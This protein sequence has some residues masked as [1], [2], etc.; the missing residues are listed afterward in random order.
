MKWIEAA[1]AFALIMFVLATVVTIL[2]ESAYKLLLTREKS[3]RLMMARLFDE[4][5]RPRVGHLLRGVTIAQ[6]REGFLE[7]VTRNQAYE[8]KNDLVRQRVQPEQLTSMTMMQFADRLADTDVGKAIA[9]GGGEYVETAINDLAMKFERF[10][11]ASSQRF[12]DHA[13]FWCVVLSIGLAFAANVDAVRL[14]QSLLHDQDL[15]TRIVDKYQGL[16]EGGAA[17]PRDPI[18]SLRQ[19]AALKEQGVISQ[20]EMEALK[21][22]L[23]DARLQIGELRETG[24]PITF[25]AWPFCRGGLAESAGSWDSKCANEVTGSLL[26]WTGIGQVAGRLWSPTGLAWFFSVLLAGALVGLGAPFWFDLAR[27]LARSA[28]ML[29]ALR[30]QAPIEKAADRLDAAA[31]VP[32]T[33]PVEAFKVAIAAQRPAS[34]RI[35]LSTAGRP[36]RGATA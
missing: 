32:P 23:F 12:Q 16:V 15:T 31:A 4:V 10:G 25:D 27:G 9:R 26:T 20:D 24:L 14:V 7:T 35:L 5:L 6:A 3:F 2:M 17:R 30:R 13:K 21:Q 1:L 28:R 34:A 33:T 29:G 19:I 36:V 8:E 18:E 11:A 22:S